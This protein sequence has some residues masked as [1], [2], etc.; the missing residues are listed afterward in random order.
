MVSQSFENAALDCLDRERL[1]A[2]LPSLGMCMR[3]DIQRA[4][5]RENPYSTGF[6]DRQIL[7]HGKNRS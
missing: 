2:Y 1:T 7:K 4:I 5:E 6:P 3:G